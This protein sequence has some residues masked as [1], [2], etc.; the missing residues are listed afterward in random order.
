MRLMKEEMAEEVPRRSLRKRKS[1][2]IYDGK[3]EFE[4]SSDESKKQKV[5]VKVFEETR[6]L[7]QQL[8]TTLM[9]HKYAVPFKLP[10]DPV[11]LGIPDYLE[12]I[13]EPM[14]FSTIQ[15]KFDMGEYSESDEFARDMR[16]VFNNCRTYNAPTTSIV[17]MCNFLSSSFEKE[18]SLI[19]TEEARIIDNQEIGEMRA[20][21]EELRAEHQK[22]LNELHKLYK[23]THKQE[24]Q[25]QQQQ[26][27]SPTLPK[28]KGRPKG[29]KGKKHKSKGQSSSSELAPFDYSQKKFIQNKIS[30]LSEENLQKMV[31]L[32]TSEIS[33]EQKENA[34]G[35]MEFDLDK[36]NDATL[37]KLQ[38]FVN[39]CLKEQ[40]VPDS[41]NDD[42]TN[43]T[44]K[45][46]NGKI[47]DSDS[48]SSSS[49]SDS[50][51]DKD[52]IP[53]EQTDPATTIQ[54]NVLT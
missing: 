47:S 12:K 38:V 7:C 53:K 2:R 29:S 52:D 16:L 13:T 15:K 40:N 34:S 42:G 5:S 45:L 14:D 41:N 18:F 43:T 20:V 37:R 19:K 11:A 17:S 27:I 35:T 48:E 4:E 28:P 24:P 30:A 32:L 22:L 21:I 10:V 25:Q 6:A 39:N 26:Q 49:S 33:Q 54:N 9:K 46:E 31:E 36:M 1:N 50:E 8:L 51:S 23:Q 44:E 3:D